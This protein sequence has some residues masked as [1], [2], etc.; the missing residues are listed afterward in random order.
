MNY[1]TILALAGCLALA[2]FLV[3]RYCIRGGGRLRLRD[4]FYLGH[5]F[6]LAVFIFSLI[7]GSWL[8]LTNLRHRRAFDRGVWN[9]YPEQRV[10][11]VDDLIHHHLL[12]GKPLAGVEG[13]LG[14]P[15]RVF[16]DSLGCRL[17]YYLGVP[18]GAFSADPVFLIVEIRGGRAEKYFVKAGV[19]Y[20]YNPD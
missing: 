12:D 2:G 17:G 13:L 5:V 16:K 20:V 3:Y 10:Q 14:T 7:M 19:P 6:L 1:Q 18:R 11:M 4:V 8:F 9:G 15:L